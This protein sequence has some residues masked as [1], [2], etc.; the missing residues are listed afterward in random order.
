MK[1]KKMMLN[2]I[3]SILYLYNI[4][5]YEINEKLKYFYRGRNILMIFQHNLYF[6]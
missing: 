4:G 2:Y 6:L 1:R 3:S 5:N